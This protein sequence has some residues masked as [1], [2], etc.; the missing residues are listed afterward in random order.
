M[1]QRANEEIAHASDTLL[2]MLKR[3]TRVYGFHAPNESPRMDL[4]GEMPDAHLDLG[5]Y[6]SDLLPDTAYALTF[7]SFFM[8]YSWHLFLSKLRPMISLIKHA[9]R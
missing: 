7:L 4:P 8:D 9:M 3:R 5:P 2:K 1:D 6:I